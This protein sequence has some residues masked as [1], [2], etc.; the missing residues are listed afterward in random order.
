MSVHIIKNA[1]DEFD[2]NLLNSEEQLQFATIR[3]KCANK[4]QALLKMIE[5]QHCS[6]YLN[7]LKTII[8]Q[9]DNLLQ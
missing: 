5:N 1:L 9:Y 2:I 7:D 4:R 8:I 3:S 6:Y